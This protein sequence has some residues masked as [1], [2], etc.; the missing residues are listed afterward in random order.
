[1][2][3]F[4]DWVDLYFSAWSQRVPLKIALWTIAAWI[5]LFVGL[6]LYIGLERHFW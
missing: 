2:W 6:T 5:A 1:M 3:D 4:W